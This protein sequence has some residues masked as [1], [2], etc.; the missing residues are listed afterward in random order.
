MLKETSSSGIPSSAILAIIGGTLMVAGGAL[1]PTMLG[2]LPSWMT[3]SSMMGCTGCGMMMFGSS[4]MWNMV[5]I[6]AAI[7]ISAGVV[8]IVGGYT[9]YKKPESL[10]KWSVAVLVSSIVGLATM[11]GFFIGPVLGIFGGILALTKN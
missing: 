7:S 3:G 5:G 1:T 11:S 9:I 6:M 10:S 2:I 8:S 4:F